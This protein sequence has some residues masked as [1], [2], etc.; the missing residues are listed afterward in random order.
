MLAV[1]VHQPHTLAMPRL[2]KKGQEG[3]AKCTL[4]STWPCPY[5]WSRPCS[6]TTEGSP[7][8]NKRGVV[9][10]GLQLH[11]SGSLDGD[12]APCYMTATLS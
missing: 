1:T 8:G 11:N 7:G 12:L 3:E 10:P 6:H 4:L 5:W 2:G 9:S